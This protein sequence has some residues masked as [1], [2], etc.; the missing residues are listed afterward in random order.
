MSKHHNLKS[1]HRKKIV[2]NIKITVD[3]F[4]QVKIIYVAPVT[5]LKGKMTKISTSS[6]TMSTTSIPLPISMY[7]CNIHVYMGFL[8]VN[9]L[10]FLYTKFNINFLIIQAT[11]S[12]EKQKIISGC[13]YIK[14]I[15]I[16]CGFV[17]TDFH[18]YNEFDMEDLR[19]AL[20]SGT[21]HSYNKGHQTCFR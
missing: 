9:N 11:S 15:Y 17:I 16:Q 19:R 2:C 21:L 7:H 6:N 8:Y 1:M 20:M 14:R 3:D 5:I 10:Y 12:K 13:M 4:N 18:R